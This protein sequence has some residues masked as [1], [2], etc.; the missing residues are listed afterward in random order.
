MVFEYCFH[1]LNGLEI[2]M[3]MKET[4][5]CDL[6][7]MVARK[8]KTQNKEIIIFNSIHWHKFCSGLNC[9]HEIFCTTKTS[10]FCFIQCAKNTVNACFVLV[11][12]IWIKVQLHHVKKEK[13]NLFRCGHFEL[14]L[15]R[16]CS[17]VFV[18]LAIFL[19]GQKIQRFFFL[20]IVAIKRMRFKKKEK[21]LKRK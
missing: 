21:N 17:C 7:E 10:S 15:Q 14:I 6:H 11:F 2:A 8:R 9:Q 12:F 19:Y 5:R 20:F 18:R 1:E 13:Q 3:K 4:R 16:L